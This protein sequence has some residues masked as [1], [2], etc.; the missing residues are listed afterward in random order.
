[1]ENLDGDTENLNGVFTIDWGGGNFV[2]FKLIEVIT[3]KKIIW[4][5]TDSNLNWLNDKKEWTYTRMSF[6][7][8]SINGKT[9]IHFTHIGLVPEAECYDMCAK[10]R[11]QYIKGS[12]YKLITEGAGQPQIKK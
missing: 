9:Q 5:V 1:M 3:D 2:T 4:L 8:A 10:D 11:D 6:E 7:I 12:L